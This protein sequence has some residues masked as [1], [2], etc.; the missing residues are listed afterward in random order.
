[1]AQSAIVFSWGAAVVGREAMGLGVFSSALQYFGDLK[2]KGQIEDLRVYLTDAGDVGVNA[3]H[4]IIEGSSPQISA[5]TERADYQVLVVKAA[6][7]ATNFRITLSATGD[8]VARKIEQLQTARKEL[9][10]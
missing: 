2:Q 6:H 3:G 9:G 1:M 5:L 4:L 7:V 8:Q 10:I